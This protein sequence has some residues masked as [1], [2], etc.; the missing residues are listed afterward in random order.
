M[1]INMGRCFFCGRKAHDLAHVFRKSGEPRLKN[2]PGYQI[3]VCR[4]HHDIFDNGSWGEVSTLPNIE[5]VLEIMEAGNELYYNRFV[6]FRKI[7]SS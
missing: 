6:E 7:K 1:D 5:W 4:E 2:E 3:L